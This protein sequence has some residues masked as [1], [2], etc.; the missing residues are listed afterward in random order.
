[1]IVVDTSVWIE[2]FNGRATPQT[3]KL[4]SLLGEAP[5]LIGDVI[6]C[7]VLQGARSDA[8]AR[9]IERELGKFDCAAMLNPELAV[10]AAGH[11]RTLRARGVTVRKTIDLIIGTFCLAAQCELLHADRDFDPMES[12]LGLRVVRA[13]W[14]VNEP[15][16]AGSLTGS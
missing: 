16:Q 8:H 15:C 13:G 11:Y 2:F 4:M 10:A 7:E 6:L 12:H 5:L 3:S 14:T 1:L 9:T